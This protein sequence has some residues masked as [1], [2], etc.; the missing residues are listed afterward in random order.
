MITL[1]VLEANPTDETE[2]VKW[3]AKYPYPMSARVYYYIRRRKTDNDHQKIVV[4][5]HALDENDY[6]S[7]KGD[8]KFVRVTTYNSNMV[9]KAH[10]KLDEV[11]YKTFF[12]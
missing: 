6:P 10:T 4:L 5:S 2:I 1:T 7:D 9:V 3:V 12:N 8:K 11:I